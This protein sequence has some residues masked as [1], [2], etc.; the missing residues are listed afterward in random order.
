M[1][2]DARKDIQ[3]VKLTRPVLYSELTTCLTSIRLHPTF[4]SSVWLLCSQLWVVI[5]V[6]ASLTHVNHCVLSVFNPRVRGS[7]VTGLNI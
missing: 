3:T 6:T 7:Y 5:G 2:V 4:L 1:R